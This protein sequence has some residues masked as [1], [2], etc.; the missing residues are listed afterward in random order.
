MYRR[1]AAGAG[2][3]AVLAFGSAAEAQETRVE[4]LE[5]Q[6]AAKADRLQPY[7]PGRLEKGMLWVEE[8]KPLQKIAPYNGFF[9][10]YGFTGR[11]TGAGIGFGGGF[12]HDL[13]D[14]GARV[15]LEAGFTFRNYQLFR[16]D[17]SLP[18]L[19]DDRIVLGVQASY[20][21]QP[22]DDFFGIGPHSLKEDR[23]N[24]RA[25]Y[26]EYQGRFILRPVRWLETGVRAGRLSSALG[27]GTDRRFPS[28]EERFT[29]ET[30]P[31][32]LEQPDFNYAEVLA[33]VDLRDQ[34]DN[35]RAGGYYAVTWKTFHDAELD[36]YSFRE[37]DAVA[38]QFFPIFDKKRVIAL[39]ARLITAQPLD[40]HRVPFYLKPTIGGSTTVRGF[41]D[42]RLRDDTALFLNAEYRWE[43]FSG[44]DMALFSDWGSIGPDVHALGHGLRQAYGIG[45][46]FNTYRSVWMRID[47]GTGVGEGV[48]YFFKF[49]K[50]F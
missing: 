32:L 29:D 23:V 4:A 46:R 19:A 13:F 8:H 50:A 36:E 26:R 9:G 38:Q 34:P 31:G 16:A 7:E 45:F 11:P 28:I 27:Q 33:A 48:R 15:D 3:S 10:T 21:H 41:T 47:I 24:F 30:A 42:Y 17:L 12:R 39:Q 40:G 2:L 37:V 18:Y 25:D 20:R 49:S 14:R 35:A 43:A 22:Q 6:R 44:L 1:I 5:Q